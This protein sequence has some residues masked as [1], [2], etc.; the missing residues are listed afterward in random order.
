MRRIAAVIFTFFVFAAF[1]VLPAGGASAASNA[2][3]YDKPDRFEKRVLYWTNQYRIKNDVPKLRHGRCADRI[4]ER[5]SHRM[6]RQ[7]RL[8]HQ[9][10]SPLLECSSRAYTAGENIAYAPSSYTPRQIVKM[11]WESPGHR[12][13]ML[14]PNFTHL[15]VGSAVSKASGYGYHTQD[16]IGNR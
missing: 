2:Y 8:Y 11:W 10:L 5:W 7:E 16:F 15:G 4:A 13:N 3:W 12:K 1:L 14:N 9:S 6:A